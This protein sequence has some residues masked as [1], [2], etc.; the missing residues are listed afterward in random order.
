MKRSML[1][2]TMI[3]GVAAAIAPAWAGAKEKVLFDL[4]QRDGYYSAATPVF[5]TS[6]NL[7]A[8]AFLGG[9][10]GGGTVFELSPDGGKWRLSVLHDF[11][12]P[13]QF[14]HPKDG[15]QPSGK[16]IFD[17]AG[18]LYGTTF[19]G[20][21]YANPTTGGGIV[22]RL[23]PGRDGAW[24][25]TVL[26]YFGNSDDAAG[27]NGGVIM[28]ASGNLYGTTELGGF[29][30]GNCGDF[31]CG[32]VF[33][34]SPGAKGKWTETIL[35][36]F[37]GGTDGN[38]PYGGIAADAS[39]NLY[40]TTMA[41]GENGDGIV[42]E[43]SPGQNG[44]WTKAILYSFCAQQNCTD[45]AF[46]FDGL[47]LDAAGDLYGT[48]DSGGTGNG[49]ILGSSCGTVFELTQANGTWTESVLHSFVASE[50]DG[51]TAGVVFDAAGNLYGTALFGGSNICD[52]GCGTVF[53]L[54]PGQNGA[55]TGTTLHQFQNEKDGANPYGGLVPAS[56]GK[57]IGANTAGP[58][59]AC[60]GQGCGA[61][62]SIKP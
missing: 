29:Y 24:T 12:K 28:D 22:W 19:R 50:G 34:L 16:L 4:S 35:Y 2:I 48:T 14:D 46:P 62:Y 6:G 42:F 47:T 49:C 7:Y 18:N 44:Q 11:A 5:D 40:G 61:V 17:A 23:A 52:M 13:Y 38:E 33:E 25:E 1:L 26:H 3:S 31:G 30:G 27:P 57:V 32:S 10:H 43:L 55:W 60:G 53:E 58:G 20:G 9:K 37:T 39:G 51:P 54:T 59:T 36:A 45:G 41:G 21:R 8:T 15:D 56:S